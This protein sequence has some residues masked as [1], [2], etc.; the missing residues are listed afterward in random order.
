MEPVVEPVVKPVVEPVKMKTRKPRQPKQR[1]PLSKDDTPVVVPDI[2]D[3]V[4]KR[5]QYMRDAK[6]LKNKQTLIA[7]GISIFYSY[8]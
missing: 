1:N 5:M 4:L 2:E 7:Q 8:L 3:L 6:E